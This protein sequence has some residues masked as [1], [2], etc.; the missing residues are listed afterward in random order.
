MRADLFEIVGGF[1][2]RF[3]GW[4]HEDVAAFHAM[5]TLRGVDQLPGTCFHL[6]HRP[7]FQAAKRT[8]EY[9]AGGALVERYLV[10]DRQGWP[11]IAPILA[12]RTDGERWSVPTGEVKP[13]HGPEGSPNG[14]RAVDVVVFTAGRNAYLERTLRS[15]AERV[16]GHIGRRT[17]LDDSGDDAFST[18]VSEEFPE[19]EVRRTP[20]RIGFTQAIRTAW[21]D[22]QRR[23][24]APYIFHL[25]EDF[26]FDRDV[27]LDELIRILEA[28]PK[29][30]QAA[31]LRG[32]FFPPEI[33]AG[34]IVEEDPTAYEHREHEGLRYLVHRKFFTT[35]PCVYRRSLIRLGWPNT[36]HS[37]TRF[38]RMLTSKG[39]RFAFLGDGEPW[40]SHIGVERTNHGY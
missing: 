19:Y 37:E 18:W 20:G 33:E 7:S 14:H 40:V 27:H 3:H 5:R 35:N 38:G 4:G 25:E 11:A 2:E 16:H 8:P 13:S 15:F 22:E 29:I 6:Y 30:A 31:L 39:Y 24:G 32:P 9:Q 12:E 28:E 23:G 26:T 36:A 17:I 10:A 21:R 1:D 34:G